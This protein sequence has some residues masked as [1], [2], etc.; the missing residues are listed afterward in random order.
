MSRLSAVG[1]PIADFTCCGDASLLR[2]RLYYLIERE[3]PIKGGW[4][5]A[6]AVAQKSVKGTVRN[7]EDRLWSL[8]RD[9]ECLLLSGS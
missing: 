1:I 6:V 5:G 4:S 8:Q 9:A 3:A 2:L 7:H